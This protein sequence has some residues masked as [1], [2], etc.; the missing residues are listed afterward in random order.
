MKLKFI[1]LLSIL[2]IAFTSLCAY[3]QGSCGENAS[4]ELNNGTL[5]ITGSGHISDY[6][7]ENPAPWSEKSNEITAL[8][9]ND[10]ITDIGSWSFTKLTELKSIYLPSSLKS[11]GERAFY[12]STLPEYL[13]LPSGI[14]TIGNGAFNGCTAVKRIDM[15]SSLESVGESAFMNLPLLKTVTIPKS[16]VN[17]GDWAFFGNTGMKAM[18]FEGTPPSSMGKFIA[19]KITE[20]F[21]VFVPSEFVNEWEENKT[22]SKD[23]LYLYNPSERIPVYVNNSEVI[24]DTQPIIT[25]SRTLVPVRA[26]FEAMD[27][28]VGWDEQT[29]TVASER[30]GIIIKLPIGS[31]VMYKNDSPVKIDVPAQIIDNRTLVPVRVISEA[32]GANVEWDNANRCVNITIK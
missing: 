28:V 6:S 5:T 27:A 17:I 20:D 21:M 13:K 18:Y 29:R 32:F 8:V 16:T 25:D 23:N 26:I 4:W 9:I 22:F 31:D 19:G 11:I 15:P 24:F 2:I 10:G 7:K 1:T 12:G 3:A 30:N 14:K